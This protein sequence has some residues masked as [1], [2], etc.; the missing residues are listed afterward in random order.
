[1]N[2]VELEKM[3]KIA[4]VDATSGKARR[5]IEYADI[6]SGDGDEGSKKS[7]PGVATFVLDDEGF[8]EVD[9]T[10]EDDQH[11]QQMM[12]F[13]EAQGSQ[14]GWEE[15]I[16]QMTKDIHNTARFLKE[17]P[18]ENLK[19]LREFKQ[20]FGSVPDKFVYYAGDEFSVILLRN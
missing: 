2:R 6:P 11:A 5:L 15:A 12:G 9:L 16:E 14:V 18:L 1:M 13:V 10:G 8:A 3:F 19:K 7:K 17:P 4:G 20:Q